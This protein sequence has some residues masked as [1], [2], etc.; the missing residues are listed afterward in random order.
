MKGDGAMSD[1]IS[2]QPQMHK[3]CRE[4]AVLGTPTFES[5]VISI[6]LGDM[7]APERLIA[8]LNTAQ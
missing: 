5:L 8:S 4:F 6:D 1:V 3:A 2:F 7:L